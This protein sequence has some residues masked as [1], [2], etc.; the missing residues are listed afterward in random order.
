M[1]LASE[2]RR[3]QS[4]RNWGKFWLEKYKEFLIENRFALSSEPP[5]EHVVA[6]LVSLRKSGKLTWQRLQAVR[7]IQEWSYS[8]T[9][10]STAQL[11][12]IIQQLRKLENA[13]NE[14]SCAQEEGSPGPISPSEHLVLQKLRAVMR[15]RR[16]AY[17]TEKAYVG[18]AKRFITRFQLEA[19]PD[20]S[21]ISREEV[22][23]FLSEL[24]VDRNVAAS[25]QNQAFSAILYIF[26]NVLQ[27]ELQE[28]NALRAKKP[29]KLPV[30]LDISEVTPIIEELEGQHRLIA[31]ML[32]GAGMRIKECLT[33]RIKDIDFE[34]LQIHIHNSKG[35][36]DRTTVLPKAVIDSLKLQ[37]EY[38]RRQH[39]RDLDDGFGGVFMPDALERKYPRAQFEFRWQYV[40]SADRISRDPRSG[41]FRRH[42]L[43]SR[44]FGNNFA[45]AIS[46]VKLTKDAHPHTLRHSF[47]THLLDSGIDIRTIQEL[48]GHADVSTTMIY[49]HVSK[50]GACG[51]K[52]P[53]DRLV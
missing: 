49:T 47:A 1:S 21:S 3:N 36:K 18:W 34:R 22:E 33:L 31:S 41:K 52:S 48:L 27:R 14:S 12:W 24:A 10:K 35:N 42:H 38:R 39:Q 46:R 5:K 50:N 30:V 28:V 23:L 2:K 26:R 43:S 4:A 45:D 32:Y 15:R 51:V 40:F 9:G 7:S 16:D 13:E 53:L 19:N 25:T 8:K 20:W 17:T 6:F 37:I 29:K 44:S 11:D